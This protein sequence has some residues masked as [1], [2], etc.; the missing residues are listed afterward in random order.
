MKKSLC[1]IV[2]AIMVLMMCVPALA[3]KAS[4]EISVCDH[5]YGLDHRTVTYEEYTNNKHNVV[6][7]E[8]WKCVRCGRIAEYQASSEPDYHYLRVVNHGCYDSHHIYQIKCDVCPFSVVRI[9][10]CGFKPHAQSPFFIMIDMN[11]GRTVNWGMRG[12][13]TP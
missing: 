8:Y 4:P 11:T 1:A 2:C 10:E 9:L 5:L 7:T 6:T 13:I 3:E 12:V